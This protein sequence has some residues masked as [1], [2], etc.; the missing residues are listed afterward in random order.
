M[1][2]KCGFFPFFLA[3]AAALIAAVAI[4]SW[5][6]SSL[7]K[8]ARHP[9]SGHDRCK[10]SHDRCKG[11][12]FRSGILPSAQG[13][14]CRRFGAESSARRPNCRAGAASERSRRQMEL[15]E[16]TNIKQLLARKARR[17]LRAI[18]ATPFQKRPLQRRSERFIS[19]VC[20][21]PQ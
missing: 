10:S 12:R 2:G 16:N 20:R 5:S 11:V 13:R 19:C 6:G 14:S 3:A 9:K 1:P 21:S 15:I 17:R 4:G 8:A 7:L 18:C